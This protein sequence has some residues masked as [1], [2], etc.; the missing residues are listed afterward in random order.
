MCFI[1]YKNDPHIFSKTQICM[2]LN[3]F[4]IITRLA[5]M[6]KFALPSTHGRVRKAD[7]TVLTAGADAPQFDTVSTLL[8]HHMMY[9]LQFIHAIE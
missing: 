8:F 9:D 5:L 3:E 2:N 6:L 1:L 4:L 7:D